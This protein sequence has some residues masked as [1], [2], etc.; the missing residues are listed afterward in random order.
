VPPSQHFPC[1]PGELP[2]SRYYKVEIFAYIDLSE[3]SPG[4]MKFT[5]SLH[6][7]QCDQRASCH[8]CDVSDAKEYPCRTASAFLD[9]ST[10]ESP[11]MQKLV[12]FVHP[13][14]APAPISPTTRFA[15]KVYAS[16]DDDDA[17]IYERVMPPLGPWLEHRDVWALDPADNDA[18][19]VHEDHH[20]S[21]SHEGGGGYSNVACTGVTHDFDAGEDVVK[22]WDGHRGGGYMSSRQN[23]CVFENLCVGND[24]ELTMFLPPLLDGAPIESHAYDEEKNHIG[25][26]R[27]S[28]FESWEGLYGNNYNSS[29]GD[30]PGWRPAVKRTNIPATYR[31]AN[32]ADLHVFQRHTHFYQHFGH[33]LLDDFL[34]VFAGLELFSLAELSATLV[35]MPKCPCCFP[36]TASPMCSL[37]F[38][39]ADSIASSL[40]VGGVKQSSAYRKGTCFKRVMMGHS[41]ALSLAYPNPLLSV[42]ARKF[43]SSLVLSVVGAGVQYQ[44]SQW[45]KGLDAALVNIS[46]EQVRPVIRLVV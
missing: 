39:N 13:A 29:S 16:R 19:E 15:F 14:D 44:K 12:G 24:G 27:L 25:Y 31:F 45:L 41:S 28:A 35:L 42:A 38:W 32:D 23:V 22:N 37:F 8:G 9:D 30:Y 5:C 26:V 40:F 7:C 34:S 6:V 17:V 3:S 20:D 33:L 46:K 4:I 10:D 21:V 18:P 11:L 43:R 2:S 1:I 36:E